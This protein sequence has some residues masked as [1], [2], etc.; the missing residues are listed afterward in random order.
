MGVRRH[1]RAGGL[2]MPCSL[3]PTFR[4]PNARAMRIVGK[5]YVVPAWACSQFCRSRFFF[6][7]DVNEHSP[8]YRRNAP[9]IGTDSL[10]L[11]L[12]ETVFVLERTEMKEAID[13]E[14]N[15]IVKTL[16][17]AKFSLAA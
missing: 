9:S 17:H 4:T 6:L 8:G 11:V 10:V 13:S 14:V 1:K 3:Y 2:H 12:N 16:K 7:M 5:R 15:R